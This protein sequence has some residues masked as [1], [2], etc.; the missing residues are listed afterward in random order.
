MLCIKKGNGK[1]DKVAWPGDIRG[2][3]EVEEEKDSDGDGGADGWV[4]S[5]IWK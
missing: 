1:D 4:E 5:R 3:G 2:E